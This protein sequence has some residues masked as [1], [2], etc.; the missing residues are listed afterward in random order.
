M[1]A[2][3]INGPSEDEMSGLFSE[4]FNQCIK[5]MN[6]HDA[7]EYTMM[8]RSTQ[9]YTGG[10]GGGEGEGTGEGEGESDSVLPVSLLFRADLRKSLFGGF[11]FSLFFFLFLLLPLL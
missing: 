2:D 6:H 9:E 11:S 4:T 1:R 10:R 8:H 7:Q 5:A 3:L